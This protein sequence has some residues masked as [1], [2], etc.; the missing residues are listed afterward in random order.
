MTTSGMGTTRSGTAPLDRRTAWAVVVGSA[1]V[2]SVL[3]VVLVPWDWLPGGTLR[4]PA[5]DQVFA[6][7]HL[8]RAESYAAS[9]RPLSWGSLAVST[10]LALA[11]GLTRAGAALMTRLG[12]RLTRWWLAVPAG[13]LL[14]L[15][16]GRALTLPFALLV[17]QRRLEAGLTEQGLAAWLVD[18]GLG[19]LVSWVVLALLLL[20]VVGAARLSPRRWFLWA[21]G[22]VAAAT[23]VGS[24]LYPVVVEPLFNDFTPMARGELRT[25]LLALADAEGV[26]VDEVLVADASR[27]TTT[28]NAYVSGLGDTRRI[29]VYDTLLAAASPGEVRSVVA[30]E[31]AHV[32]HR[33]VFL[34]TTLGAVG[35][36]LGISVLALL[37]QNATFRRRSGAPGPWD[38]RVVPMVAALVAVGTLA[39]APV[40]NAVSRA[41]EARA[42]RTA[43][44]ATDDTASFTALQ[45]RL[46]MRS[47]ADPTPPRWSQL[48]FGSHPTVLQ[49][50]GI[51]EAMAA[52]PED[53]A[54]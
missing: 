35:G 15:A 23:F 43:L 21:G 16:L 6:P 20:L 50:L 25:S 9:V 29:V 27:R 54:R 42:D 39:S 30:H 38:P 28:L 24:L 44:A 17:R 46:A 33:D 52:A 47:L 36:V 34:G 10:A 8:A 12:N 45:E 4:P 37:L 22:G 5:A 41:V 19:L 1:L 53:G 48:W 14:L 7:E 2:L 51:A 3:G 11:L 32:R 18:Q 40:Q 49:R 31:I 13:A 26:E